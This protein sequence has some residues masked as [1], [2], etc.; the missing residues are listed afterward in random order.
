MAVGGRSSESAAAVENAQVLSSIRAGRCIINGT[1]VSP[2]IRRGILELRQHAANKRLLPPSL[3]T[4][5]EAAAALR[6]PQ[7]SQS[8]AALTQAI[9]TDPRPIL[10]SMGITSPLPSAADPLEAF[11]L[12][13]EEKFK[14]EAA[15]AAEGEAAAAASTPAAAAAAPGTE[16]M[17][18]DGPAA[19]PKKQ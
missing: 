11:A 10:I 19:E 9:L 14:G 16:D 13:L 12:A 8:L 3:Q 5:A 1:L 7:L 2:D 6:C 4:E 15:T 17:D 18:Q